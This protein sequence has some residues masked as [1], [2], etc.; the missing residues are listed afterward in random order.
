LP[1][2]ETVSMLMAEPLVSHPRGGVRLHYV[3][4]IPRNPETTPQ[5]AKGYVEKL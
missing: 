5:A 1:A 3:H 2:G 4:T